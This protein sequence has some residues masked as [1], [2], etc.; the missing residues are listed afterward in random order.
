MNRKSIFRSSW[1][2][3]AASMALLVAAAHADTPAFVFG[4][5]D[6]SPPMNFTG[7]HGWGFWY[8]PTLSQPLAITQLGVFDSGED[9]LVSAHQVGFWS[10]D[11]TLLASVTVPAG[12]DA[13]LIG[14]YRFASIPPVFLAAQTDFY[15]VAA[16]FSA[17]D[18]DDSIAPFPSNRNPLI[19]VDRPY[20]RFG[21]GENLPFPGMETIPP[22]PDL[23]P[24]PLWEA[25]FQFVVVPEPST[26]MLISSAALFFF[27]AE[28][29]Q[30]RTFTRPPA[31][32]GS[33]K[34]V[35]S[36]DRARPSAGLR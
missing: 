13:P 20:G 10:N 9:G 17:N 7:T 33:R 4:S 6:P 15:I 2:L 30:R 12:T 31:G 34:S 18:P 21:L 35:C 11:G 28:R 19:F 8:A 1:G 36:N 26:W 5:V 25:N 14:G 27:I 3:A 22:F 29:T 32:G 24:P 16:Q 23:G